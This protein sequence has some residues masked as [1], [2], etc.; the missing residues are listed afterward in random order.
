MYFFKNLRRGPSETTHVQG[1]DFGAAPPCT[2]AFGS[3]DRLILRQFTHQSF[4]YME[5]RGYFCFYEIF[6]RSRSLPIC[7]ILTFFK[8]IHVL[9]QALNTKLA[10]M[11]KTPCLVLFLSDFT[12]PW[13]CGTSSLGRKLYNIHTTFCKRDW[14][15][16]AQKKCVS[17]EESLILKWK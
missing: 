8:P 1:P 11:N 15:L 2:T 9:W 13:I 10:E 4:Y 17:E 12:S 16:L 7:K 6:L 3:D 5:R 14:V